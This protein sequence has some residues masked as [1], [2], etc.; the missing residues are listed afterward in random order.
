MLI[1][2]KYYP[3]R[4]RLKIRERCEQLGITMLSLSGD[5]GVTAEMVRQWNAGHHFPRIHK[6]KDLAMILDCT[7]DAL[8]N[9]PAS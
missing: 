1:P 4:F 3:D 2:C 7:M 5:V 6:L 9:D 8:L